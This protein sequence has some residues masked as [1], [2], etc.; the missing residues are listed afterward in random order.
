[1]FSET[2]RTTSPSIT[3]IFTHLPYV[4][5][6]TRLKG[7]TS[8][9]NGLK[10]WIEKRLT[11]ETILRA[12]GVVG[13]CIICIVIEARN[14]I[15]FCYKHQPQFS[16]KLAIGKTDHSFSV[17]K[18]VTTIYNSMAGAAVPRKNPRIQQKTENMTQSSKMWNYTAYKMGAS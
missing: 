8:L 9:C 16:C 17:H 6:F 7:Y 14:S 11:M 15:V 10:M 13:Q 18:W 2:G 4:Q 5:S 3:L 12:V 1:M